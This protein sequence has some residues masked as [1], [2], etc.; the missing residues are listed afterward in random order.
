MELEPHSHMPSNRVS[1]RAFLHKQATGGFSLPTAHAHGR[2]STS[3][4]G[5]V[6]ASSSLYGDQWVQ[7]ALT[8]STWLFVHTIYTR[9][10]IYTREEGGGWA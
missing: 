7:L 9:R 10:G 5:P 8:A 1:E 6:R 2:N 3:K 4:Q